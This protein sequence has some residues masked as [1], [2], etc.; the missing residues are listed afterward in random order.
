VLGDDGS[1]YATGRAG[2]R[3]AMRA[4]DGRAAPT[5]LARE[6][7]HRFGVADGEDMRRLVDSTPF[8][9]LEMASFAVHVAQA[10]Q[11]GDPTSQAIL[12]QA[13]R[14]LAEHV[15]AIIRKL[16]MGGEA[17]PVGFV[18][19]M[20][21]SA[22]FVTEPFAEGVR[23]AAPRAEIRAPERPPEVGAAI[24]GWQRL[25]EGDLGSWSLGRGLPTGDSGR[26]SI[27]RGLSVEQVGRLP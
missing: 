3:A 5:L 24:L 12:A 11:A 2:I 9:K 25:R 1:G 23:A 6:L 20:F 8:G 14:D 22:P 18:G 17:F 19:G 7:G 15:T 13:G 27:P 10:A 4:L 16:E 26:R 21:K